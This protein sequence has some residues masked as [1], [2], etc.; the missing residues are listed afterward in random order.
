MLSIKEIFKFP[1]KWA[2][3]RLNSSVK[4]EMNSSLVN[5]LNLSRLFF[6][7]KIEFNL[8]FDWYFFITNTVEL[9]VGYTIL[10]IASLRF[11]FDILGNRIIHPVFKVYV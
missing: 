11:V 5:R 4:Q 2:T 9:L 7:L 1:G 8:L 6:G 3:F 10:E